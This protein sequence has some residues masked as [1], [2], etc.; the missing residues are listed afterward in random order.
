ME[1]LSDTAI[2][3]INGLHTERLDYNSEYLPLIDAAQKLEEYENT[4]LVPEE[5][6]YLKLAS[7]GKAIAE[8]KEFDGV[9]IDRFRE[10]IQADKEG[11]LVVLDGKSKDKELILKLIRLLYWLED[12]INKKD[13][14][15]FRIMTGAPENNSSFISAFHR[16]ENEYEFEIY[17]AGKDAEA[18]LKGEHD[19]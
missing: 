2:E 3:I 13:F 14:S 4:G 17:L 7:M 15:P 8:I 10:L 19:G 1:R 5:V 16:V 11:R 6:E 12:C 9:P 18:A